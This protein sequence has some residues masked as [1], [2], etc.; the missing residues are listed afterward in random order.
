LPR[1][2]N[3]NPNVL[4]LVPQHIAGQYIALLATASDHRLMASQKRDHL[5]SEMRRLITARPHAR[6]R[7]HN[8]TI[9]HIARK[10][11]IAPCAQIEF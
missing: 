1:P 11:R 3:C 8:L 9:L 5:F 4:F 7:R 10:K 6:I 2:F